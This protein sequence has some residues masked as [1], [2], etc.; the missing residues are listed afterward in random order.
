MLLPI[1]RQEQNATVRNLSFYCGWP[2]PFTIIGANETSTYSDA[3]DIC[4]VLFT[5]PES[6]ESS[7]R[8]PVGD[9]V[10]A[11][12]VYANELLALQGPGNLPSLA[13]LGGLR[14]FALGRALQ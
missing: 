6:Q 13:K 4:M 3:P 5:P 10:I 12:N 2:L 7:E 1:I 11:N 8:R 9:L 14:S